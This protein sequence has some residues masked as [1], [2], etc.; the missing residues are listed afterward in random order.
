MEYKTED[1]I[2]P[3]L[4]FDRSVSVRVTVDEENICLFVGPRDWQWNRKT[5]KMIGAGTEICQPMPDG[6]PQDISAEEK[7]AIAA[8]LEDIAAGRTRSLKEID[9]ELGQTIQ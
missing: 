3:M 7:A 2:L 8:G 6:G 5:G 1:M 9:A 4:K